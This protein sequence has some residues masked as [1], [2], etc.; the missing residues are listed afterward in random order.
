MKIFKLF[1]MLACFA[2]STSMFAQKDITKFLGIPVDGSKIE[3]RK[4]LIAKG[5]S[6]DQVNDCL[7]GQ[8]NGKNVDVF[9]ATNNDKVYRIAVFDSNPI[10]E[11]DIKI[12]F[13]NL[14]QQFENNQKYSSITMEEG[15]YIIPEDEDISYEMSVNNKRYEAAYNQ[16]PDA[17]LIDQEAILERVK[18][19]LMEKFTL[20]EIANPTDEQKKVMD[21]MNK[22][23][24]LT[25]MMEV[26]SHKLVWFII[27]EDYG[28]YYISMFYDNVY[29]QANGED[30]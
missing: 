19:N 30:L 23:L 2:C 21:E 1:V 6:Y 14:C 15:S 12:R 26:A 8:F 17:T 9:I 18:N 28:K 22:E 16:L 7:H 27:S 13:N 3:M 29:N 20:E 24:A 5:F 11:T 10:S 25:M 4:K